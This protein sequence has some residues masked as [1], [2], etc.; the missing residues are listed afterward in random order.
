MCEYCNCQAI[1]AI[2]TLTREHDDALDHMRAAT[3][4]LDDGDLQRL[5]N[6]CSALL[7]L[8]GPHTAVEEQALFPPLQVDFPDYMND[9]CREH[10]V[11]TAALSEATSTSARTGGWEQR[12]AA[13]LRLLREHIR[14]EQDGVFPVALSTF[15]T[16]QWEQL[17]HV[18]ERLEAAPIGGPRRE[19]IVSA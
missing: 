17:E 3:E 18:R 14:K 13:A 12:L 16:A 1:P 10:A 9:L 19:E 5:Q 4:A 6:S 15:T 8:L 2:E 11:V 7:A